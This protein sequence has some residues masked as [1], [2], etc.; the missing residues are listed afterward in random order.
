MSDKPMTGRDWNTFQ[1]AI[2]IA[3][4]TAQNDL[5]RDQIN[6]GVISVITGLMNTGNPE[7]DAALVRTLIADLGILVNHAL[8]HYGGATPD[9]AFS[10]LTNLATAVDHAAENS[11]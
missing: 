9:Q 4:I 8:S 1:A 2:S 6:T 11:P 5:P 7:H 10:W 3:A